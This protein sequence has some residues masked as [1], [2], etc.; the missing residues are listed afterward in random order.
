M[1][2]DASFTSVAPI[3]EGDVAISSQAAQAVREGITAVGLQ[4][5]GCTFTCK[6]GFGGKWGCRFCNPAGHPVDKL[7]FVQL[8]APGRVAEGDVLAGDEGQPVWC[9]SVQQSSCESCAQACTAQWPGFDD[10]D[11]DDDGGLLEV[12]LTK[13]SPMPAFVSN[14]VT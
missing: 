12:I 13:P 6:K 5:H 14:K 8:N 4:D 10:E 11:R 7:L 2:V 3:A 1:G 9:E